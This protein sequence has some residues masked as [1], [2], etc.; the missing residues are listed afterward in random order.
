MKVYD[1]MVEHLPY[2]KDKTNAYINAYILEVLQLCL[3]KSYGVYTEMLLNEME[4]V[5]MNTC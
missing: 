1:F 4:W 5:Y 2:T 3:V